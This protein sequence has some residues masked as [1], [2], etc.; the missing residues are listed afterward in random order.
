MSSAQEKWQGFTRA[1]VVALPPLA[2]GGEAAAASVDGWLR[3]GFAGFPATGKA[4]APHHLNPFLSAMGGGGPSSAAAAAA[5]CAAAAGGPPAAAGPPQA[6]AQAPQPGGT[7]PAQQ[8][9]QVL[10]DDNGE[11]M[12]A[13]EAT[14]RHCLSPRVRRWAMAEWHYSAL[15][16]PWFMRNELQ[17]CLTHMGLGHVTH[18]TR[19]EWGLVRGVFGPPRRL[20]LAF[21]KE[22]R[23]KLEAY[24]SWQQGS[25]QQ[26]SWQQGPWQQGPWQQ[27]WLATRVVATRGACA[28]RGHTGAGEARRAHISRSKHEEAGA[29]AEVPAELPRPLRVG[30]EVT[31]RHPGTRQLHDGQVL[32]AKGGRYR[33]Q[34]HRSELMSEVLRDID[35]MPCDPGE[36]L[37]YTILASASAAV[38]L[39]L[40]G[41]VIE[42]TGPN[43]PGR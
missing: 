32:T 7:D 26:G 39:L 23:V 43:P 37:S 25:W 1:P 38:P 5:P 16:R 11:P 15:D 24:R 31:A 14:L 13:A 8:Q 33:V 20:S 6:S 2:L 27:G 22:E 3:L 9:Q 21:L 19:P 17:E 35:I 30:Q 42:G 12:S 28:G 34:F 18:L 4:P 29:G 41:R 10:L 40:N 36:N